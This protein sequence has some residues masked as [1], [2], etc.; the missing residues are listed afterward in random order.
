[1]PGKQNL[2]TNDSTLLAFQAR[3]ACTHRFKEDSLPWDKFERY[4][5]KK[6]SENNLEQGMWFD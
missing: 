4:L 2:V 6:E 5:K 1:M 3:T